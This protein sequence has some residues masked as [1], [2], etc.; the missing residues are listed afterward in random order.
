MVKKA[1]CSVTRRGVVAAERMYL[2][3]LS[4]P[5]VATYE[6]AEQLA[7]DSRQLRQAVGKGLAFPLL[8]FYLS[9]LSIYKV[10]LKWLI[11]VFH[12]INLKVICPLKQILILLS[13][14]PILIQ[15]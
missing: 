3:S 1:Q 6:C 7:G 9:F 8:N 11:R 13:L 4:L 12:L 15:I 5:T 14:V 2:R 10:A